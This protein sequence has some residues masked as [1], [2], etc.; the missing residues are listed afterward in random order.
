MTTTRGERLA[1]IAA[2]GHRSVSALRQ[3]ADVVDRWLRHEGPELLDLGTTPTGVR[4]ELLADVERI[5]R[6]LQV[7]RILVDR[8]GDMIR[9]ARRTRRGKPVRVL[10][11][12][13]GSGGF[14]FRLEDWA[15]RQR[16]PIELLGVE[17]D[18]D[19]VRLAQRQ[20][21]EEGRRVR[22]SAGDA[23][24]LEAFADGSVDIAVSTFVLHHLDPGDAA[25]VL[26]ELDR[27]A[28]VNFLSF[29][30]RRNL[31]SVPALWALLRVG[32][33]GAPTRHDAMVSLRKGYT[34]REVLALLA[35][36]EIPHHAVA[37][38]PPT[39]VVAS[40]A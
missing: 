29:D 12:G 3:K 17:V 8:V 14:L 10:D 31:A 1:A 2:R 23:R 15:H 21:D 24:D 22:F 36:A 35:A 32:R 13:A 33:F 25:C 18:E 26:A 7:H 37:A 34:E 16:I 30:L 20:A 28:A 27:V 5:S 38:L 6:W 11:V 39:F 40:R 9:Q 4:A 19:T